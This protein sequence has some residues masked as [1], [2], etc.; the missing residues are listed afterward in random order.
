MTEQSINAAIADPRTIP[1][2]FFE[3]GYTACFADALMANAQRPVF[4]LTD[5][6]LDHAWKIMPEC[7]DTPEDLAEFVTKQAL[8]DSAPALLTIAQRLVKW[9]KDFP[10]NCHNGYAGLKEL[11]AII[12]DARVAIAG[13]VKSDSH[14]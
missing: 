14:A 10:V 6:K 9:D 11:D 4:E 2:F 3:I 8:S 12:A 7:C 5:A 13:A 1:Q